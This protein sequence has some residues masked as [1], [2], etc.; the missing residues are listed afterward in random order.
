MSASSFLP[1]INS[2]YARITVVFLLL[3]I[4]LGGSLL[5][6]S[7]LMS[8]KYSQEIMQRMNQ[9]VAMYVAGYKP[10]LVDRIVDEKVMDELTAR[11]MILNPSL[12]LYLLD[13]QGQILSHRLPQDSV[14]LQQVD[15]NPVQDYLQGKRPFPILG[16]DPRQPGEPKAISVFPLTDT[17]AN[18]Q[19]QTS[20]YVYAIIGGQL[21]QQHRDAVMESYVIRVG[22]LT[23]LGSILIAAIAGSI[24]FFLLTRRLTGL[25]TSVQAFD[26]TNPAA[27]TEL[28]QAMP[29]QAIRRSNEVDQLQYAFH[30]MARQISDQFDALRTLDENRRELI[31]NVSHDLRTPLASMQGY[32]ETLMLKNDSLDSEQR[33]EH[34]R[35]AY[36]HSQRLGDLIKELFELARLESGGIKPEL[37]PFSLL[38]LAYDCVQEFGLLAEQKQI[39]LRIHCQQEDCYVVADIA[40]IHRV[41]QNLIDNAI[42]HTPEGG[43]VDVQVSQQEGNTQVT[44]SD[45]GKG[46]QSHDIPYIFERFYQSQQQQPAEKIGT[47]LGLAIVKRILELHKTGI[48]VSS[49]IDQGTSFAFVLQ[50]HQETAG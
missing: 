34:L 11:A 13:Q 16:T 31:A 2:L 26:L 4:L 15:M 23:M 50:G 30:K 18:G 21:Y 29:E 42:R 28:V 41:L 3:V 49:E 27:S 36:K 25:Q 33:A 47:G 20:G 14:Q 5:T 24:V 46:I 45:T 19:Q 40:L 1:V 44:V 10:L 7:Q 48:Q 32:I 39:S 43:R 22:A 17:L 6:I 38:E 12:E 8:E 35:V 9:S 37:E